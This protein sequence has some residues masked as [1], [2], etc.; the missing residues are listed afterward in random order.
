MRDLRGRRALVTGASRGIGAAIAQRLAAEGAHVAITA[1]TFDEGHKLP[2]SLR[3]TAEQIEAP[4]GRVVTIVADLT[5]P[6]QRDRIV[7]EAAEGLGGHVEI[8]VNNAAAAIY[9]PVAEFP[10]RRRRILF[11]VNVHAPTDLAQA[12]VP[13]MRAA[14]EGW[15]VSVSSGAARAWPGPPFRLGPNGTAVA[16]YGSSKAALSRIS[17]GLAVELYGTGIRMNTIEPRAAVLSEGADALVGRTLD[18]SKVETMEEMVEA[19]IAL[20][21]CGEDVT[22]QSLVSLDIID[23]WGLEVRNIDGTPR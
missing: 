8:L 19:V 1:R 2:G 13:D 10:L 20:C 4:G 3:R 16:L 5:D 11:E 21:C 12:V 9:G 23:E 7:P 6:N 18:P 15:I 17:N 14:G 22:G